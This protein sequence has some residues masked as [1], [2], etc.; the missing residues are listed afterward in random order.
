[1]GN[2]QP[3]RPNKKSRKLQNRGKIKLF[4]QQM[5]DEMARSFFKQ[6]KKTWMSIDQ[7]YICNS[8]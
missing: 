7:L 2:Q 5:C 4:E 6:S 8:F 3:G 1:M